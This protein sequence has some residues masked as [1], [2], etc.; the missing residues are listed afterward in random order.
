[1]SYTTGNFTQMRLKLNLKKSI[2]YRTLLGI[3]IADF[4]NQVDIYGYSLPQ[5]YRGGMFVEIGP[6]ITSTDAGSFHSFIVNM[7]RAT[8]DMNR[9]HDNTFFGNCVYYFRMFWVF[10]FA[11]NGLNLSL[12]LMMIN[13]VLP[14]NFHYFR[15]F[16]RRPLHLL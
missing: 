5:K 8:D 10:L 1:M 4:Y 15:K 7:N 12:V 3:Y 14:I 2:F 6:Y 16:P 11:F 13:Q 9:I